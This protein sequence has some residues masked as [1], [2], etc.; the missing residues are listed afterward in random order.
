[1]L[2]AADIVRIEADGNHVVVHAKQASF[3]CRSTLESLADRL[4]PQQFVRV[5]RSHVVRIDS[6]AEITPWFHGDYKLRLSD[7]S[8]LSWSRRYAA[9][10]SDLLP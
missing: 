7:G 8:E 4:D 10:R 3:R 2:P 6:I 9:L 1:L 5:H